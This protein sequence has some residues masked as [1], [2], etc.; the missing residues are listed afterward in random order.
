MNA[1]FFCYSQLSESPIQPAKV[2]VGRAEAIVRPMPLGGI[3]SAY[4]PNA[5]RRTIR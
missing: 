2:V 3:S 5:R 4:L 1:D